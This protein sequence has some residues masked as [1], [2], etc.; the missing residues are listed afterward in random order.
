MSRRITIET[1]ASG[2][3]QFVSIKRSRSDSHNHHHHHHHHDR[4][5]EYVKL[6]R[7]E[8]IR[9]VEAERTLQA[10]NHRLVC[11]VNGLKESLTTARADL[12]QFGSVVVPKLECQIAA[13]KAENEGL[14]KSVE[15]ATCQLH[16]SYKLVESLETKIEHLEKDSKTLKCQN[17][18]LKHRVKELSRQLS[19]SC[20]RRVSDLAREVEHWKERMCYWKNQYDDLYQ[21]YNEMCHTLRLR[22]EKMLAY[23]EILRRHHY[24]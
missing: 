9:L 7:E 4:P 2:K 23:E 24:I 6:R 12:H 17:D 18:D 15:N 13:L 19:E 16:A 5:S 1:D 8:W 10:T 21:R 11:E 14:Q 3:Q 22:T 20:S